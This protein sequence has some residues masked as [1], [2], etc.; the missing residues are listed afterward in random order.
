[1]TP[2]IFAKTIQEKVAEWDLKNVEVVVRDKKWIRDM[3]ME[4]FWSV[5]QG[6]AIPPVLLEIHVN[7]PENSDSEA[8]IASEPEICF[9]GKGVTFDTGGISIKPSANMD[10]MLGDM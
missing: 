8:I 4:S 5:S 3:K 1:M 9:V 2:E 10:A 7:R 6:S